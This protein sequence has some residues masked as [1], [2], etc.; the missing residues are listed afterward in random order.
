[1]IAVL[2]RPKRIGQITRADVEAFIARLRQAPGREGKMSRDQV[3]N[4]FGRLRAIYRFARRRGL[5]GVVR[6][7]LDRAQQPGPG[8]DVT[9]GQVIERIPVT[10]EILALS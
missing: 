2:V 1:M 5:C 8:R 7:D 9:L 10:A 6:T 4:V 3:A